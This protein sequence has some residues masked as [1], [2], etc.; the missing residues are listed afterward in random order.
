[1]SEPLEKE[2]RA[3]LEQL[4]D[5]QFADGFEARAVARWQRELGGRPTTM[6]QI[7]RR[8]RQ[9]VPVALAASLLLALYTAYGD[10]RASATNLS[11]VA[12][13][14]GWQRVEPSIDRAIDAA[15]YE[16]LYATLYELPQLNT[17]GGAR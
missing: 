14:L 10:D 9:F 17:D 16:S 7:E 2:V 13:A 15:G 8:A 1:M 11:I 6:A 12:R 5:T 3:A 4:R